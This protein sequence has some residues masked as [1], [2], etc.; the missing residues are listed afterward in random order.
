MN[1]I[2]RIVSPILLALSAAAGA[3]EAFAQPRPAPAPGSKILA[4]FSENS[5]PRICDGL[6]RVPPEAVLGEL[7]SQYAV[8]LFVLPPNTE[9]GGRAIPAAVSAR[10]AAWIIESAD[11]RAPDL[12]HAASQYDQLRRIRA[13]LA[14]YLRWASVA[15]GD[16][17]YQLSA[18]LN[19]TLQVQSEESTNA[20]LT[21]FFEPLFSDQTGQVV[22]LTCR[23]RI[24]GQGGGNN[25]RGQGGGGPDLD[26]AIRGQI[27]DLIVPPASDEFKKASSATLSF[28]DNNQQG[29][30]TFAVN[31][32]VGLGANL[33]RDNAFFGFV[34]YVRNDQETDDE[35]DEDDAKDVHA[36][37][38]GI[39]FRRPRMEGIFAANVGI[40]A[41]A[42]FD[43]QN[44]AELVRAR[45]VASDM[46]IALPRGVLCGQ[47]RNFWIFYAD[48]R[49]GVF[50]EA[51]EVLDPGRN[52]DLLQASDDEYLGSGADLSL[53][54]SPAFLP[55]LTLRANYRY[56]G[57][58]S[59]ELEDPERLELLANFAVQNTRPVV[60]IGASYV[61]GE[62]F[63]TFQHEDLW[64]LT[65]GLRF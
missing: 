12:G 61:V 64:K 31:G 21:A 3:S 57:V 20:L 4:I 47:E 26:L 24:A 54:L 59:G 28:T 50:L 25:G 60:S 7:A 35:T 43:L 33:G 23:Q 38:P 55:S 53:I 11:V 37:S 19:A 13:A 63:E 41:Y 1:T 8:N 9:L 48:C 2:G 14:S 62:N 5:R 6:G 30:T 39:F 46:S 15:H 36:I 22:S 17:D 51:A 65:F 44:D 52:S 49:L 32:V 18:P 40:T 16:H 42:T 58:I 10:A 29:T 27:D 56:M 34:H 45:L